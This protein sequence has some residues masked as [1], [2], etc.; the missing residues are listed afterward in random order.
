MA[1]AKSTSIQ[2][3]SRIYAIMLQDLMKR[4]VCRRA[5]EMLLQFTMDTG[6]AFL[7]LSDLT[8]VQNPHTAIHILWRHASI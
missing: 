1:T 2:E 8:I 3:R 5:V 4:S 7:G 6:Q